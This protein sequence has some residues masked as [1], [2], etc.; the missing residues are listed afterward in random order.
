[1]E[2]LKCMKNQRDFN[3]SI[4]FFFT[5]NFIGF[6]LPQGGKKI[7]QYLKGFYCYKVQRIISRWKRRETHKYKKRRKKKA[8]TEVNNGHI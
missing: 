3:L 5:Y 6:L 1:M 2:L 8:C 4:F 7:K